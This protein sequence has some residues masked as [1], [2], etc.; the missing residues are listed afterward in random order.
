M[1]RSKTLQEIFFKTQNNAYKIAKD[2]SPHDKKQLK[3]IPLILYF[4]KSL[5]DYCLVLHN[6]TA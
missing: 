1:K 4:I 2:F 6:Y 5:G 3:K